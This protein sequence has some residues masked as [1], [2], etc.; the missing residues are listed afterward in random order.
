MC[1]VGFSWGRSRLPPAASVSAIA[2]NIDAGEGGDDFIPTSSTCDF[3]LHLPQYTSDEALK[4]KLLYACSVPAQR[5]AVEVQRSVDYGCG[6]EDEEVLEVQGTSASQGGMHFM[7]IWRRMRPEKAEP[8]A[9]PAAPVPPPVG[10]FAV[11]TRVECRVT[12]RTGDDLD[13]PCF[14]AEV[15]EAGA[16]SLGRVSM[17]AR[18]SECPCAGAFYTLLFDDRDDER[19]IMTQEFLHEHVRIGFLGQGAWGMGDFIP[20]YRGW[21]ENG[22]APLAASAHE[23]W[24]TCGWVP[25]ARVQRPQFVPQGSGREWLYHAPLEQAFFQLIQAQ[26][27]HD[28]DDALVVELQEAYEDQAMAS[29][30]I[31]NDAASDSEPS[32]MDSDQSDEESSEEEEMFGSEYSDDY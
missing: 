18:L 6:V 11:G 29:S 17:S 4:S 24:R 7:P 3:R 28:N 12:T 31:V 16:Q 5:E 30:A 23:P 13:L 22:S 26:R 21:P 32:E 9:E 19:T 20:G 2:F 1:Q 25:A 8:P 10:G 14:V 15:H 27:T